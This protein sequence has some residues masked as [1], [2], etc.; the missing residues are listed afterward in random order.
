MNNICIFCSLFLYFAISQTCGAKNYY[1]QIYSGLMGD[2]Q[3]QALITETHQGNKIIGANI[4]L[5][6]SKDGHDNIVEDRVV[7]NLE[8]I[9]TKLKGNSTT[10]EHN[11][12]V[13]AELTKKKSDGNNYNFSGSIQIGDDKFYIDSQEI[14]ALSEDDYDKIN[15]ENDVNDFFE[16]PDQFTEVFPGAIRTIVK[17]KNIVEFI[18]YMRKNNVEIRLYSI[19][20]SCDTL[21]SDSFSVDI[22]ADPKRATSLIASLRNMDGV[23]KSGW[24][25]G[26]FQIEDAILIDAQKWP[27][28]DGSSDEKKIIERVGEKLSQFYSAKLL[29]SEKNNATGE[30]EFKLRAANNDYPGLEL[31]KMITTSIVISQESPVSSSRNIIWIGSRWAETVDEAPVNKLI[32]SDNSE[33]SDESEDIVGEGLTSA[34]SE[35]FGGKIW[36]GDA[37]AWK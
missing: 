22:N 2:R 21:K 1:Y 3:A 27:L 33:G 19:A 5:C 12:P 30:I 13:V 36:D 17:R 4:D 34:I 20:I 24:T 31:T 8:K 7:L 28:K 15:K 10:Q 37:S 25:T 14:E 6:Y 23:I 9:G 16:H 29:S 35:S 32:L 26:N 18:D 11:T